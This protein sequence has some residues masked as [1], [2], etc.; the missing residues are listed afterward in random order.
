MWSDPIYWCRRCGA[1]AE[2]RP[3]TLRM[4]CSGDDHQG[5]RASQVA[6][7]MRG[8]HPLKNDVKLQRPVMITVWIC[9]VLF[10]IAVWIVACNRVRVNE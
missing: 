2:Q 10:A 6:R 5:Q 9:C 4:P 3:K 7:L 8:M 1:Y